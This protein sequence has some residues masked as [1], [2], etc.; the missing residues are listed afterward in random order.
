M[1]PLLAL[2]QQRRLLGYAEL[3]LDPLTSGERMNCTLLSVACNFVS[4]KQVSS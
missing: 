2:L 1:G 4:V 3:A